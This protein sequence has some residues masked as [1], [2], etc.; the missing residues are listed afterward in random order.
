MFRSSDLYHNVNT[1]MCVRL[2]HSSR[3]VLFNKNIDISFCLF[4]FLH[5]ICLCN[6]YS[7]LRQVM[8]NEVSRYRLPSLHTFLYVNNALS[9][10]ENDLI[11]KAVQRYFFEPNVLELLIDI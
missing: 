5:E 4:S 6:K 7:E 9:Y 8:L 10:L 2:S 1:F 3:V 11:F